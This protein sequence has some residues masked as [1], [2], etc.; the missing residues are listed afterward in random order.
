MK[1]LLCLIGAG[2]CLFAV[3]CEPGDT[4]SPAPSDNTSQIDV[5][6]TDLNVVERA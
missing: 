2:M 1:K 4:G 5:Q 6:A 3:G